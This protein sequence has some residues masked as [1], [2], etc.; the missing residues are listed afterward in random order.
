MA[1]RIFPDEIY[2]TESIGL[3]ENDRLYLFSDGIYEVVNA[4]DEI[5]GRQRLE[6]ALEKAYKRSMKLGLK[7]LI[8]LSRSWQVD[9][10]FGDD[11]ALVGLEFWPETKGVMH[12]S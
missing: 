7:H 11:V 3:A 10:I 4:Q 1:N 2:Q 6:A 5:W 9:G 8:H 12:E